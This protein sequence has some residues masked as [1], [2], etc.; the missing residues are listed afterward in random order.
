MPN[1]DF[2]KDLPI[3]ITTEIEVAKILCNAGAKIIEFNDDNKYDLKI[4]WKNRETTIEI[5]EDFTCERTN[6]VGVEFECRGKPSGISITV[7]EFYLYKIHQYGGQIHFYIMKTEDLKKI[8]KNGVYHSIVNGGDA[9]SNSMNYLFYLQDI[10]EIS[11][12]LQ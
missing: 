6:N 11:Q 1:Y 12:K 3:A 2:K 4:R 5:K 10:I 7:A 8:I 9:G